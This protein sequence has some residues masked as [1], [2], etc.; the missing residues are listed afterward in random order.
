MRRK[1]RFWRRDRGSLSMFVVLFTP[2]VLM[3]AGLVVDGGIALNARER[4]ADVAQQAARAGADDLSVVSL[5]SGQVTLAPTACAVALSFVSKYDGVHAVP[6]G[7]STSMANGLPAVNVTVTITVPT[8]LLDA[9]GI[10][11][12]TEEATGSA[13]PVCGITAGGQC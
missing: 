1:G 9:I 3:L 5:R 8:Q 7:C 13:S 10:D 2:V 4:A 12:F 11:T 6:D